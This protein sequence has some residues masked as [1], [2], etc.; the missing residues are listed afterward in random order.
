MTSIALLLGGAADWIEMRGWNQGRSV[1]NEGG[2][3]AGAAIVFAAGAHP[4]DSQW[5]PSVY[6]AI[7]VVEEFIGAELDVWNAGSGRTQEE[8]VATL[9]EAA[10]K[11]EGI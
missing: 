4:D 3:C 2:C 8:V 10:R 1:T 11:A 7:A 6:P 5:P 9:R